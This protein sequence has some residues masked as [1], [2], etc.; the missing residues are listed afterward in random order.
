MEWTPGTLY[1]DQQNLVKNL[2]AGVL[3]FLGHA[4]R[5]LGQRLLGRF[6][7]RYDRFFGLL[8]C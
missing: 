6:P 2:Y 3:P 8:L 5:R 7:A 1:R 4:V